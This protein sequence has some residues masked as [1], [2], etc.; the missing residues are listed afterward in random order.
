MLRRGYVQHD[1]MYESHPLHDYIFSVLSFRSPRQR[2]G[3]TPSSYPVGTLDP[4][5][6]FNLFQVGA[7]GGSFINLGSSPRC[8]SRLIMFIKGLALILTLAHFVSREA[9]QFSF[10]L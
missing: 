5:L 4:F 3:Y 2:L 1:F 7:F 10:V 9:N 8:A 6:R